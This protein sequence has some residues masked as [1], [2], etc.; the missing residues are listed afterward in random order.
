MKKL[1]PN[2]EHYFLAR[3]NFINSYAMSQV[4]NNMVFIL[5]LD[6]ILIEV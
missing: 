5:Y 2:S 1:H 6:V 4:F 3:K